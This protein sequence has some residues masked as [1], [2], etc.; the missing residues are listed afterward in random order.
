MV[1]LGKRPDG[2]ARNDLE[3][4]IGRSEMALGITSQRDRL[5]ESS[6]VIDYPL[7]AYSIATRNMDGVERA[8]GHNAWADHLDARLHTRQYGQQPLTTEFILE[9]H[10]IY[11]NRTNPTYAGKIVSNIRSIGTLERGQTLDEMQ[12]AE[13]RANPFLDYEE[14]QGTQTGIIVYTVL[15]EEDRRRELDTITQ[16]YNAMVATSD[17]TPFMRAAYAQRGIAALHF[18]QDFTGRISRDIMNWSLENAGENPS[19]LPDFDMDI[20]VPFDEWVETVEAGSRRYSSVRVG[21]PND[22]AVAFGLKREQEICDLLRERN[23]KEFPALIPGKNHTIRVYADFLK[24]LHT[25]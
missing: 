15:N 4:R 10:R 22:P 25:I 11:A 16:R 13:V 20:V 19:L 2:S 14:D 5:L 23:D 24:A 18:L 21:D 17:G 1:E 7:V 12:Q 3:M 9:L 6:L 8:F